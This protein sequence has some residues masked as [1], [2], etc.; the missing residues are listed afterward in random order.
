MSAVTRWLAAGRAESLSQQFA[1]GN[2][3][4]YKIEIVHTILPS[5]QFTTSGQS[6]QPLWCPPPAEDRYAGMLPLADLGLIEQL[7]GPN[8]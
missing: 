8:V 7:C 2:E 1:L 6:R 4:G 5:K 3:P